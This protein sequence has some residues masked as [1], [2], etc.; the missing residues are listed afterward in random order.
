MAVSLPRARVCLA[1]TKA[2]AQPFTNDA[3]TSTTR[4]FS[5]FGAL[6]GSVIP[7]STHIT[8]LSVRRSQTGYIDDC[9]TETAPTKQEK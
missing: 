5:L 9:Q 3:A 8:R 1:G 4:E 2:P 6:E 7:A